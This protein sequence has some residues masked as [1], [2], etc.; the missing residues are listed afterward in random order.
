MSEQRR[1][2]EEIRFQAGLL[3]AVDQAVIATDIHGVITYWNRFAERLYG[4]SAPEVIGRN[5]MDITPAQGSPRA[6]AEMLSRW[7]RGERWTGEC[8]VQ[9]RDGRIFPVLVIDSPISNSQE[10][11]IGV[12]RVSI[13]ITE[14]KRAE[15]ELEQRVA[16][17]TRQLTAVNE[18]LR[19]EI[20][21]RQRSEQRLATQYAITRVLAESDT[22]A[23][24]T[25]HLLQAIGDSMAW[26]WGAL[27]SVDRDAGVLR[28][29]SIWHAPNL[30]AAEF[31]AISREIA[32]TPGQGLP[33]ACLAKPQA[34]LDW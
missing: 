34:R 11:L 3:D 23:A 5:M 15:E 27:W 6:A 16:E 28:C 9:H 25:P 8:L 20:I 29:E 31:D 4:W 1:A 32:F 19:K 12:V 22:L 10:V 7:Q 21:E 2:A 24:A 14:R 18:E 30:E 26:E 33:G 17:R 13:D